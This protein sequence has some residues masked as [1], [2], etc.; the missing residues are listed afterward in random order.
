M[1]RSGRGDIASNVLRS[2]LLALLA[3]L[4]A[5]PL[6][7]AGTLDRAG[8]ER[9]FPAPL[10]VGERDATL[11]V[12]PILKQE[13]GSYEVFAYAFESIDLA[14]IPGFGGTPPDLLVALAPDGTFRDVKVIAH[15]EPVFLEGLGSEPLFAFV[16]QYVGMSAR[17]PIRVGRPNARGSGAAPQTTVD[18]ISMATASTRVINE[19]ILAASLAVARAKLGFGAANLG[20]KVEARPDTGEALTVAELTTRGWLR[21]LTVTNAGAETA[22]RDAGVAGAG[23]GPAEAP[24]VDLT[25][26]DL[27]V[28]AIGRALL[29]AERFAAL[30]RELGPGDHAVLVVSHGAENP[31]GDEF[32]LGSIPDRLTVMQGG[33]AVNARD[34]AIERRGAA[35]GLPD[36]PWTILRI[37]AAAGFDPSAPWTL[38]AKIVRERGQI[39]PEKIAREFSADYALPADL[40]I[41]E[42]AEA[43]PSWT[44]PWRARGVE[45]GVIT[46]A[47]A[48]L[49][50]VLARQ[51]GLVADRRRFPAFRLA[52]LAFTLLFIGW[53]AQAQLSIV[54][55]VGLVRAA[56]VTHD[57]TFLLYDPPS[58]LLW[59]FV[60]ATLVV[61]GRGTF[62]GWLCP[63]GALQ[64]FVAWLAKPLRIR[65]VAVSPRL[66]RALRQVKYVLLAGI[67]L[68]AATG[69]PLADSLSEAEP[70]KTAITL[71]FVRAWPFVA[72][73]LGLLVLNLFVYKGFCRYL[74]PLGA[75]LAVLGRL[76][77]LDWIPRRAECGSPC[78]LCKVRCRYGAIRSDGRIDY[79]ECFQCMDCVTIIH[80]PGQCVP[81]VLARRRGKRIVP[82][83]VAAE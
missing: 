47:L 64:E 7:K 1:T 15:H 60:I 4:L 45:L 8:M 2:A 16:E 11:P 29:G 55:L 79:P 58:L 80:D 34:M 63:F 46:L 41:R 66:D 9:H 23:D 61:W 21:R 40:F 38:S 12:W 56:T 32:V 51:R 6:A 27:N 43:G 74:C 65:P 22:F 14:P 71:Y 69:S 70:F 52:Y 77:L 75:S 53:Y 30:T 39:F 20:L 76:R 28:P 26:A 10:V 24:L 5:V 17:R 35:P 18:G 42:A 82:Q 31:L 49:V 83:P 33:L 59:A 37:T 48:G 3:L 68:A 36:G 78:Q 67:L 13:A 73:A 62:C 50:P 81:E 19:S 44:D 57:L 54:T 25:F 72:Y